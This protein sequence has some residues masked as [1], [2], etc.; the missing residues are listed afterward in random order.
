MVEVREERR[1]GESTNNQREGRERAQ[2]LTDAASVY[3]CLAISC[4]GDDMFEDLYLG[5]L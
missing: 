5:D 3:R 2:T 4:P 1:S